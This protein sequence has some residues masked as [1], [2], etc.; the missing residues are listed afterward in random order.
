MAI[1][2]DTSGVAGRAASMT[3]ADTPVQAPARSGSLSALLGGSSVKV[4]NGELTNLEAL[5]ARMRNEH[6]RTRFSILLSSL[7]AVGR[8]L[9]DA[10]RA[11][12]EEGLELT[13]RADA[14][15]SQIEEIGASEQAAKADAAIMQARIDALQTQIDQAIQDGKDHNELVQEQ[16]RLRT[17]LDEKNRVVSEAKGKI[18][19]AEN[20]IASSKVKIS[21]IASS[22]GENALKTIAR[23]F[24]EA[25]FS[26]KDETTA[27]S[28]RKVRKEAAT[29]VFRCIRDALDRFEGVLRETIDGERTQLV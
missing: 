2:L 18:A 15:E 23:E 28:D 4:T 21:A 13:A 27:E 19:E 11:M 14:L 22:I 1:E 25:F 29:D 10:Q 20:E 8:S 9:T 5:V 24:A 26:E 3:A 6:E 17:E 7:N 16:K 12:L